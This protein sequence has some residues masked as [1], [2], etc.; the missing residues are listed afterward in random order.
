MLSGASNTSATRSAAVAV[1]RRLWHLLLEGDCGA[2]LWWSEDLLEGEGDALRLSAKG[3]A[4]APVVR[5]MHALGRVSGTPFCGF[6]L[7]Q[8]H[9][10][11]GF[12]QIGDRAIR[13]DLL[14]QHIAVPHKEGGVGPQGL[15]GCEHFFGDALGNASPE[16]VVGIN[17]T[18]ARLWPGAPGFDQAIVGV[19]GE[20][21]RGRFVRPGPMRHLALEHS[22]ALHVVF[23][24]RAQVLA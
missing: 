16:G 10:A 8:W 24:R 7:C 9:E 19:V 6:D 22:I 14:R 15:A 17:S 20:C 1:S 13:L 23:I 4:L 2:I 5:E 21:Q 11:I 12:V 18:L 3:R